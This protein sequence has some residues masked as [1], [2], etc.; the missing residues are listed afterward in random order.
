[1]KCVDRIV[2][3]HIVYQN[4][5][6]FLIQANTQKR[7]KLQHDDHLKTFEH[8][9]VGF[10]LMTQHAFFLFVELFDF[11]LIVSTGTCIMGAL[12]IC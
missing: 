5:G 2:L 9:E 6:E 8:A 7:Q 10:Y 12:I 3:F 11:I 1:M 4:G